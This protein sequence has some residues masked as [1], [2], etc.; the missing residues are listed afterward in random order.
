MTEQT[1]NRLIDKA[2]NAGWK[3]IT[4]VAETFD[5][6]NR[7]D[8]NLN[9]VIVREIAFA[10]GAKAKLTEQERQ[11]R[12]RRRNRIAAEGTAAVLLA[13]TGIVVELFAAA[14]EYPPSIQA[15]PIAAV[16]IGTVLFAKTMHDKA[17]EIEYEETRL[18][19]ALYPGPRAPLRD[20]GLGRH[21]LPKHTPVQL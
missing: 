12:E 21:I 5:F 4:R 16:A 8:E 10:T 20:Q 15:V 11:E 17:Q 3:A 13:P 18:R 7:V 6:R 14:N 1:G 2:K 19:N 9:D